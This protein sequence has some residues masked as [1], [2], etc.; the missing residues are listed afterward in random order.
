MAGQQHHCVNAQ[1]FGVCDT[2]HLLVVVG[3]TLSRSSDVFSLSATRC[4]GGVGPAHC[5]K[6]WFVFPCGVEVIAVGTA[7]GHVLEFIPQGHP[8]VGVAVRTD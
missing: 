6:C 8:I 5:F 4:V 2:T 3:A 1:C 7:K